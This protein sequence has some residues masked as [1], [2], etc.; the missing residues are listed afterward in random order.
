MSFSCD[1]EELF[2]ISGGINCEV[3][4]K[5]VPGLRPP[6]DALHLY[7]AVVGGATTEIQY[8]KVA[9]RILLILGVRLIIQNR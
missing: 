3:A 1:L 2:E 4:S 6:L 8:S 9:P 7:K 5:I